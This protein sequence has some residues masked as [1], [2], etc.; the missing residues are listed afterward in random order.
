MLEVILLSVFGAGVVIFLV[1]W[2]SPDEPVQRLIE[3]VPTPTYSIGEA[4]DYSE[5][6][7]TVIWAKADTTTL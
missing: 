6:S 7:A 4:D 5:S 3:V 1:L 2:P